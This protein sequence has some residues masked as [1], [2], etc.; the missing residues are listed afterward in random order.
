VYTAHYIVQVDK[1]KNQVD[2]NDSE[3]NCIAQKHASDMAKMREEY[4]G[5]QEHYDVKVEE[6]RVLMDIKVQLDREIATYGAFM[7]K[8]SV[9]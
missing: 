7:K 4:R 8:L 1:H 9:V 5:L 3:I 6:Y 2:S